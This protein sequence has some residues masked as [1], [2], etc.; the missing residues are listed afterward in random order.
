MASSAPVSPRI[1]VI[2]FSRAPYAPPIA[3]LVRDLEQLIVGALVDEVVGVF[4][5]DAGAVGNVLPVLALDPFLISPPRSPPDSLSLS[6]PLSLPRR[7]IQIVML[8]MM[9]L[10][11]S[12]LVLSPCHGVVGFG[13]V[14][15][16]SR[17]VWPL[18]LRPTSVAGMSFGITAMC[19]CCLS[20]MCL[21]YLYLL[22]HLRLLAEAAVLRGLLP[23]PYLLLLVEFVGRQ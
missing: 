21:L 4:C 23:H 22:H 11:C 9:L 16:Y 19:M 18:L 17:L 6:L 2:D 8:A 1:E 3:S 10:L 12:L 14:R 20:L 7:L 5:G 15:P 13:L